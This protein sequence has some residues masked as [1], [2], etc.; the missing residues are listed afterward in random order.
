[1]Q[2]WIPTDLNVYLIICYWDPLRRYILVKDQT[3]S[4]APPVVISVWKQL[5]ITLVSLI[6]VGYGI[7]VGGWIFPE[8]NKR[9]VWNWR[10]GKNFSEK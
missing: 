5:T 10:R 8:I 1:M 2:T 3:V 7:N 4:R 9:R 6:A